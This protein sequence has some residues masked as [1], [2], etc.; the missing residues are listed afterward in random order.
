M[1][2][3]KV[4]EVGCFATILFQRYP[5]KFIARTKVQ[6]AYLTRGK[7]IAIVRAGGRAEIVLTRDL[8]AL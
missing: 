2:K 8:K 3:Q 4:L 1:K 7:S 6:I 5:K